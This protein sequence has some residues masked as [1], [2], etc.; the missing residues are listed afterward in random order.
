M[1]SKQSA[2]N[3]PLFDH[4][5]DTEAGH[6]VDQ[7][8]RQNTQK[9]VGNWEAVVLSGTA[10]LLV[11]ALGAYLVLF[12]LPGMRQ[13]EPVIIQQIHQEENQTPFACIPCEKLLRSNATGDVFNDPLLR[14][15]DIQID[16][17]RLNCCAYTGEQKTALFES[18][19]RL[20]DPARQPVPSSN[21]S[22]FRFSP[23]SAHMRLYPERKTHD[24]GYSAQLMELNPS[25]LRYGLEHYR[26]VTVTRHGLQVTFGGLYYIYSSVQFKPQSQ[27]PCYEFKYKT[28]VAYVERISKRLH[29][30]IPLL[31]SIHSC[32]DG[33]ADRQE[34]KYT[35]G[36]FP[37]EPGD[38]I[39]V[40]VY[41]QNLVEFTPE[42]SYVGLAMLGG[43]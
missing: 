18:I 38:V 36:V 30:L 29:G 41:G 43:P 28:F 33:C 42:T 25:N 5:V 14:K 24:A 27:R 35:G 9:R 7:P 34:T 17:G 11:M 15:L 22:G 10:L 23:A 20:Q 21:V 1:S 19:V 32:C 31:K 2:S 8:A 16:H 4:R 40:S 6:G 39:R 3:E 26:N 12:E 37:L 13:R